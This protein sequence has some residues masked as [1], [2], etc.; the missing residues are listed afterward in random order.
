MSVVKTIV[1]EVNPCKFQLV[2][3][4]NLQ[5]MNW[6]NDKKGRRFNA[7]NYLK[8]QVHKVILLHETEVFPVYK[9]DDK[10]QIDKLV[11]VHQYNI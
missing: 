10:P 3:K 5:G 6:W 9:I 1:S 7:S 8:R 2:R 11:Y 4:F